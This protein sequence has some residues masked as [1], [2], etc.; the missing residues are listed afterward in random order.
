[1]KL[2]LGDCLESMRNLA[3]N[4][5]DSI[6]TDPPYLIDFMSKD[7]DSA[8]IDPAFGHYIAG[9]VD[10]EGCFRIHKAHGASSTTYTCE[11]G[12]KLRDDDSLILNQIHRVLKIGRLNECKG[13]GTS[14]PQLKW[15]VNNI[16]DCKK[17]RSFFENFPLRAK[18]QKDFVHWCKH[19][20]L[21]SAH[22]RGA[23]KTALKESYEE[24]K[25][26]RAYENTKAPM[27]KDAFFH[28]LWAK[29]AFRVLKPGGHILAFSG[30]RT[31]HRMVQGIED[32]GF[33][34]RDQIMWIYGCLSEDTEILT[35][36][37][38][39]TYHE[40]I[41]SETVLC[42]DKDKDVFTFNQPTEKYFYAN[43]DT[44]YRIQSDHT[45]QLVSKNHRCLVERDGKFVFQYAE[46]LQSEE[47]VPVLE[48]LQDLPKTIYSG[49]KRASY[50]Q[51]DM[52]EGMFTEKQETTFEETQDHQDLRIV[53]HGFSDEKNATTEILLQEMQWKMP[54][55]GANQAFSQRTSW[56]DAGIT[57]ISKPQNDR[58]F[59]P[60][61]EGRSDKFQPQGELS[62]GF[63]CEVSNGVS[64]YGQEGWLYNGTSS[65]LYQGFGET[66]EQN[67]SYTSYQSQPFGQSIG[68]S[69]A[70]QI[71]QPSQ[72]IRRD[73]VKVT[74]TEYN[75]YFWCVTVST[76]AFVARRNGK[77]F[78]TGNSGFPKSMDISK[79]ID[80][81]AGAEREVI[82]SH[83]KAGNIKSGK[84]HATSN[85]I[86]VVTE[87]LHTAPSTE[88]AKKWS[89]YGTALK[90]AVE[91][92][93]L[94][95]KPLSE[96]TVAKNVLKHGVGG[97][98]VDASR[99]GLDGTESLA[100]RQTATKLSKEKFF[101]S[102]TREFEGQQTYNPSGRFPA[103]ILFEGVDEPVLKY[104]GNAPCEVDQK[105]RIFLNDY[106]DMPRLLKRFS[107]LSVQ[108][109]EKEVLQ[110]NLLSS[111]SNPQ[112]KGEE[113]TIRETPFRSSNT[114]NESQTSQ[115]GKGQSDLQGQIC[116]S[117]CNSA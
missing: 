104:K 33:E 92:I 85:E 112:D 22:T 1:M 31:Y 70:V 5:V 66:V 39:K 73:N 77:I 65:N 97:L 7:W 99:I 79:A 9:L 75:G 30:T 23:D 50:T 16:D 51:S 19:L 91:P 44:A 26:V 20:D 108:G 41:L 83:T 95:R 105:I 58:S 46:T 32:A 40:G 114:E 89:G 68:K 100:A 62:R 56:V 90:P 37:G 72:K 18:K 17:L 64:P 38:W 59:K 47:T 103:N 14:K 93:C 24:M 111:G 49:D 110:Q 76:G 27:N 74:E 15:S 61:V 94:A 87:I 116:D 11:F 21:W 63:A 115:N 101:D 86:G 84:M 81:E 10:G 67:R 6:V 80:K 82:G 71:E 102:E 113:S 42:Y 29:E 52:F 53:R 43:T 78:I 3:D 55:G 35:K 117:I 57:S 25:E 60:S 98:N 106:Q 28:Y 8:T 96:K 69:D 34:I 48:S 54:V 88:D 109:G 4:S 12:L 36:D 45:D 2:L 13:E 107:D